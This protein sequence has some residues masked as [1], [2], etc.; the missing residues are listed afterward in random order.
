[1]QIPA[2]GKQR[3][4][5]EVLGRALFFLGVRPVDHIRRNRSVKTCIARPN[6]ASRRMQ[7]GVK[8]GLVGP[9]QETGFEVYNLQ[10]ITLLRSLGRVRAF[11]VRSDSILFS[12]GP[13]IRGSR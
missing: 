6:G 11:H 1:T 4:I 2:R 13:A 12:L 3:R 9:P 8:G 5:R 10:K 7:K